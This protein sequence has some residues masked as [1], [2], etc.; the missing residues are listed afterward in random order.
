M[1]IPPLDAPEV[2]QL[3]IR[4]AIQPQLARLLLLVAGAADAKMKLAIG[5]AVAAHDAGWQR[6]TRD[7]DVFARP[8]SAKRLLRALAAAG[9][10][11]FWITESHGVAWIEED[12]VAAVAAGEAPSDRVDVRSTVTEPE[13]SAIR[14]AVPPRSLGV[15]VKVFRPDHLAAIKFLAGR[16]QDLID[17]DELIR[18]GVDLE[19]VRLIVASADE[20][21]LAAVTARGR[22]ALKPPGLR[23]LSA[24]YLGRAALDAAWKAAFTPPSAPRDRPSR[25]P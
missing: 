10:K 20:T 22:R 12:N 25:R 5:G 21:R 17:F 1:G 11:T 19:R 18:R 8:V 16:P 9:M 23:E 14:T 6:Y 13:A 2:Q 15:P 7:L 3:S 4:E 24:P